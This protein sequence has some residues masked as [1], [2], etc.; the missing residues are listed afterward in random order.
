M[1]S[2]REDTQRKSSIKK[3]TQNST[4]QTHIIYKTKELRNIKC[5]Q[6]YNPN[7]NTSKT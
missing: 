2:T 5:I 6:E 4:N 1:R 7:A 3:N